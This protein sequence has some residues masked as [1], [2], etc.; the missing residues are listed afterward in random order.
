MSTF[1]VHSDRANV[2]GDHYVTPCHHIK[3]EIGLYLLFIYYINNTNTIGSF[4]FFFF[5]LTS[6]TCSPAANTDSSFFFLLTWPKWQI[7]YF[8]MSVHCFCIKNTLCLP[9]CSL[10]STFSANSPLVI[11]LIHLKHFH[12]S[13]VTCQFW[14]ITIQKWNRSVES[15]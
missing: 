9:A 3:L 7:H 10:R 4:L 6:H 15:I 14:S 2:P 1:I 5:C 13:R 12:P 8:Q 11:P